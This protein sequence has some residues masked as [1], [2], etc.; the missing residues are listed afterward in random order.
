MIP[1]KFTVSVNGGPVFTLQ[2]NLD[3]GN[4]NILL[5]SCVLF[6]PGSE[7]LQSSYDLFKGALPGG[8]AW[9]LTELFSGNRKK[10][11]NTSLIECLYVFPLKH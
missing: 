6:K 8:F 2:D 3:I 4:V 11:L 10:I 5:D 1:D 7:T 9:E